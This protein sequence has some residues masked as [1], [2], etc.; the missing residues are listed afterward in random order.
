MKEI[1][2][3]T[4]NKIKKHTT[5]GN[6]DGVPLGGSFEFERGEGEKETMTT[7]ESETVTEETKPKDDSLDNIVL[8][9]IHEW[10]KGHVN[11][12]V[13]HGSF[14]AFDEEHNV[15]EDRYVCYGKRVVLQIDIDEFLK[16]FNKEKDGF[17]N[18]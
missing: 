7:D 16:E 10:T 8:Q 18:W 9:A 12:V 2:N 6:E 14:V 11:L 5:I 15:I 4:T 1:D 3:M 13:F 17:V